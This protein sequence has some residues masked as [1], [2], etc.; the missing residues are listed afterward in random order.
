[1]LTLFL[2]NVT[3]DGLSGGDKRKLSL[4]LALLGDPKVI[5]LVRVLILCSF[6]LSCV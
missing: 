3:V 2:Q 6:T 4:A 1:M 5:F